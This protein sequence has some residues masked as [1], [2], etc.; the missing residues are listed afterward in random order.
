[1]PPT[2]DLS[3]QGDIT[4]ELENAADLEADRNDLTLGSEVDEP[5][6]D[7]REEETTEYILEIEDEI[8]LEIDALALEDDE[9]ETEEEDDDDR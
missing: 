8:E 3:E 1:M 4:L 2:F 9:D 6:A 7:E 5:R